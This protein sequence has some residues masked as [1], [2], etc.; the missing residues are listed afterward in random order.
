MISLLI[1]FIGTRLG[2]GPAI[3]QSV[4]PNSLYHSL[5]DALICGTNLPASHEKQLFVDT[6][7]IHLMV[8][9]GSHL[10]F[11]EI[12]LGFLPLSVRHFILGGY[13]YL[14]GFQAPVVRAFLRRIL[15]RP[16]KAWIGLTSLQLEAVSVLLALAL[17]PQWV[18]SRSFLM[19]WMCGLALCVPPLFKRARHFDLALKSYLF[20]LPFCWA[21]PLSVAWNTLL[22][23]FVGLILFPA[24]LLAIVVPPLVGVGDFIWMGFLKILELGPKAPQLPIFVSSVHLCW[25]PFVVHSGFLIWEVRWRR[26]QAFSYSSLS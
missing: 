13:C 3:C 11:I 24:S 15:S 14:T 22:T 18:I 5:Y 10:I 26:V 1:F 9:S 2:Q 12:L 4:L 20:L 6:G 19:S 16:L 8:V 23:P 7:L 25:I 21:S 17:Y